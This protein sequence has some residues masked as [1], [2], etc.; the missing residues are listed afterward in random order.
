VNGVKCCYERR[1]KGKSIRLDELKWI[2]WLRFNIDANN[3]ESRSGVTDAS[4]AGATE[5]IEKP[6]LSGR[7]SAIFSP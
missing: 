4:P 1:V 5:K 3:L 7:C 2:V 6:G